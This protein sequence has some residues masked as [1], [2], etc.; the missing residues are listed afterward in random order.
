M[1]NCFT[2][3]IGVLIGS[4]SFS[5]TTN[6]GGP[7]GWKDKFVPSKNPDV[8]VMAGFDMQQ[9]AI[10][11]S[12][13]DIEK[14]SPWRFGYKYETN[15][16]L[17]NSG[18]W[19]TTGN[20]NRI[21]QIEL[22]CGD[23]IT[24]NVIFE[25]LNIPEGAYIYLY[26][27]EKTNRVGAYTSRN[28][29]AE[30][31]LGT[32]LVHGSHIVVEY[33]EPAAVAGQGSLTIANVIHGYRSL[34]T[35]QKNLMK[36][37]ESSEDCNIDVNCP[38]GAGWEDQIRSVAMIVVGGSGICTGALINNTCDDGTPYF[39]TAN[40]CVDGQNLATW[41]FRFNWESPPGTEVCATV[42]VS[43]DPGSPYDQT[44]NG[45]TELFASAA[46]DVALIEINNMTLTDAQN[47]GCFYAGWDNSD[48]L[49]VTQATGI[50]H[51][52]GDLKKIC[53]EDN[54]PTHQSWGGAACWR[55][56]NWDQGVTEPGSSG[57]PL[58]DQ[59][60]RIIGQLYGGTAACSGTNDNS[61]PDYYGRFGVSWPNLDTW[62]APGT[63]G[64]APTTNDGWDPVAPPSNDD[65]GI[66]SVQ[67]PTGNYCTDTFDPEVT[68]HNYGANN[69]TSATI[70]YN[71][72]GGTNNT[73]NWTGTLAPGASATVTLASMTAT[74][75]AHTFNVYT[76]NPNSTADTNPANDDAASSFN[77]TIGGELI[78]LTLNIDCW[79]YETAWQILDA[80]NNVVFEGGN[81]SVIPGG[82]QGAASG[83]P[84]AYADEATIVENFC[85]AVGCYD[86]VIYDDW[87]DG[88]EGTS[89]CG[90]D[91]DYE[92]TDGIGTV[93][94][95]L[96]TVNFGE[97]ETANFCVESACTGTVDA[98]T[99]EETCFDDCNGE[100]TLTPSGGTGPYTYDIGSGAQTSSTFTGLCQGTYNIT[101]VD[102]LSCT[103]VV[104]VTLN[105]PAEV[106]GSATSTDEMTGNDG[107][108]NLT[109]T[110]GTGTLDYAWTGPGGF[111]SS[112]QDI[113]GLAAGDYSVTITD[114]NGCSAVVNV[115]VDSQL[116][117]EE[118]TENS[119]SVYP[120]PTN[121]NLCIISSEINNGGTR[122]ILTDVTGR[123]VLTETLTDNKGT[124]FNMSNFANG[125]YYLK[126]L[127]EN[128]QTIFTV[129]KTN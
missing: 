82:N 19:I 62:L 24:V 78:T 56:A 50:H 29:N 91:G 69:L 96:S 74:A 115:T 89:G 54:P 36:A 22:I 90:M 45:A 34:D 46:S 58:F 95:S 53:R 101:V 10:E 113:S 71:I 11:D 17:E 37:F 66:T 20:G 106:T 16:N 110:G 77:T 33:F 99:S 4:F 79:G 47:W 102:G 35:V 48:A 60:H 70:N 123:I 44:A 118:D 59:N 15:F 111:T 121:G 98:A 85:M 5:Q 13:N 63:C 108:V 94:A 87:G 41:A 93:L 9:I 26:D 31:M 114:D 103:Q 61:Q 119:W 1:K 51:P 112:T 129:I 97:S 100:I 23:A 55:I 8:H 122:L 83:D 84:G 81:L 32:E 21:W 25:N 6:L 76:T 125:T 88:L 43:T 109:A 18:E 52:S 75:G 3:I 39:L 57:S 64:S 28:N 30:H 124:V 42:A 117:L 86:M 72:D 14:N 49:T 105:G 38:L 128:R 73:F 120:N 2:L 107:S 12:I 126:V 92:I 116:S 27:K 67:S 80:G 68:L 40:H 65:A 104:S 127:S 7:F